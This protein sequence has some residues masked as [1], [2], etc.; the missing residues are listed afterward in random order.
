MR[1]RAR[2]LMASDW[3]IYG[4][5]GAVVGTNFV[6]LLVVA[7]LMTAEDFGRYALMW[8]AA[9]SLSA[10]ASM[11]APALLMREFSARQ[12]GAHNGVTRAQAMRLV[13]LWPI[14]ILS[15]IAAAAGLLGPR[16]A[17][18]TGGA[19]IPAR[20]VA[21]VA[22]TALVIN[23]TNV[24]AVP[25]RVMG[26]TGLSMA[27]RDA[28][29]Q[30]A[31]VLA[32]LVLST[33]GSVRPETVFMLFLGI[34]PLP[35]AAGLYL[36]RSRPRGGVDFFA[37]AP[38]PPTARA[39]FGGFWGMAVTNMIWTQIDILLG[40]LV[41]GAADLGHYQVLKRVANLCSMPQVV[42]NWAVVVT[43][44]RAH[45]DKDTPRLQA[46]CR[47]GA[48]LTLLP[49]LALLAITILAMPIVLWAYD[50]PATPM[51][52]TTVAILMAASAINVGFGANFAVAM[53]CRMEKTALVSR[54]A[55]L[56]L[57]SAVVISTGT[58][59]MAWV[60]AGYALG[61]AISNAMLWQAI[62]RRIGVDSSINAL[63]APKRAV[64]VDE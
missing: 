41:L 17:D 7:F 39:S 32:S 57:A 54:L 18:L 35:L 29:P 36:L 8:S 53:Q 51:L 60:A 11:G 13:F 42:A 49:G 33:V 9:L 15:G 14:L 40:G 12:A 46:A 52:W 4:T 59:G 20:T 55:G 6:A 3:G 61:A 37:A 58:M 19:A 27:L 24:L 16:L 26:R 10:M 34:A 63:R 23:F 30:T 21:L 5:R 45:A 2:H 22:G 44:G 64:T 28:G 56:A 43:L 1:A 48:Q 31:M 47:R 25:F 38:R 62:R 50:I